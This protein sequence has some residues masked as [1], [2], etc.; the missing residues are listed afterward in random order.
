M[1]YSGWWF[2]QTLDFD[3]LRVWSQISWLSIRRDIEF[4]LP[5]DIDPLC[6][7]GRIKI[8]F[9]RGLRISRYQVW[10]DDETVY[11]ECSY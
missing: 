3:G 5:E 2:R 8:D 4:Q 9:G 7:R 1:V 6:R 10:I 11:D